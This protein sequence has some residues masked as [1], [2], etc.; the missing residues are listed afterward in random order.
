MDS[1]RV[2]EY[3]CS[4]VFVCLES[5]LKPDV[6]LEDHNSCKIATIGGGVFQVRNYRSSWQPPNMGSISHV[7]TSS[8]AVHVSTT[9]FFPVEPS[10]PKWRSRETRPESECVIRSKVAFRG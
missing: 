5:N 4:V 2:R 3:S 6:R 7:W 9:K 10:Y 1:V 8:V